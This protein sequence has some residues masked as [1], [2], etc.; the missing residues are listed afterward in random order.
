MIDWIEGLTEEQEQKLAES[1]EQEKLIEPKYYNIIPKWGKGQKL[2][3][4][5]GRLLPQNKLIPERDC[6]YTIYIECG[7][8]LYKYSTFQYRVEKYIDK[9]NEENK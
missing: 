8:K 9:E 2:F 4:I 7:E 6:G 5:F 3:T 1:L